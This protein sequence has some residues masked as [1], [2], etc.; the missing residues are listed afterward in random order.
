M[1]AS[2]AT[3]VLIVSIPGNQIYAQ[4]SIEERPKVSKSSA[5]YSIIVGTGASV[6]GDNL[7]NHSYF[8]L[9]ITKDSQYEEKNNLS[10]KKGKFL[11]RTDHQY[12][13]FDVIPNRWFVE[14]SEDKT[15]FEAAGEVR[16]QEGE[17]FIVFIQGE[18][19]YELQHGNM[20]QISGEF[21]NESQVHELFYISAMADRYQSEQPTLGI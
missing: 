3:C 8:K 16:G 15:R 18:E 14:I 13:V 21:F 20:Y 10:V 19:L 11:I 7:A 17:L 5:P 2:I 9:D 12:M 4:N 6:N 1:L